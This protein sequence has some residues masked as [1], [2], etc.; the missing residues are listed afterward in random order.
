[1]T[2]DRMTACI[3]LKWPMPAVLLGALLLSISV[4]GAG[5]NPDTEDGLSPARL[6]RITAYFDHE[7]A[8]GTVP[9]AVVLVAQHG[10]I[11][12][13]KCFGVRDV[14]TGAPM[15]PDT[16]FALHSMTKPITSVAAMMLIDDGRLSLD[17][18]VAKYIP[19]FAGTKVGVES[20][21]ANGK[22]VLRLV[23]PKRPI[24]IRDLLRHTSEIS[25]EYTTDG[26][27]GQAYAD[28]HLFA[29]D[30]DNKTFAERI[31]QLPLA[32]QPGTLWRYGHSADVLGRVIEVV[33]GQ[34]LFQFEKARIFDPLGMSD[35]IYA[36]P[37]DANRARMA[38]PL[39]GDHELVDSERERRT[40][41]QW[42]SGGGG[43]VST[44][45]DYAQF[46]RMILN[47]GELGGRRFLSPKSFAAMTTNQIGPGS[48]VARDSGY[49]PGNGFGF[50]FGLAIRLDTGK[51][52]PS[53]LGP[54]GALE[55][56]SGSG[57][58]F[59]I[60]PKDDMIAIMMVQ[61]GAR[62]GRVQQAF[63]TFVYEALEH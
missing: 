1:M 31:A 49:F 28:A 6:A 2:V 3:P 35:T 34:S 19:A 16:L 59:V 46:A 5:S 9:G 7:V 61:V 23:P 41:R 8:A 57:T 63:K 17:D 29:G 33:S 58:S 48:G 37:T 36:A 51:T 21:N 32:A 40:H 13:L 56:D 45:G 22:P 39:P 42:Q 14:V 38:E 62:R 43:L 55:W 47:G 27:V 15:T 54:V 18:P 4:A 53:W 30:V 50:G 60:D 44:I 20:K 11:A 10:R 26:L 12:Y 25:Y 52:E 24:T